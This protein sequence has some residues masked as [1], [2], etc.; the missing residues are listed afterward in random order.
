MIKNFIN[1][2]NM[3]WFRKSFLLRI[4]NDISSEK[5]FYCCYV[6]S[7]HSIFI[8]WKDLK[9]VQENLQSIHIREPFTSELNFTCREVWF[10]SKTERLLFLEEC[11]LKFKE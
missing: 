2:D 8:C 11:L 3:K 9:E 5:R 10:D 7:W 1:S 4:Q 6:D